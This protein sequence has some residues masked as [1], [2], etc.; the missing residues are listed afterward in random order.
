[1]AVVG[2]G[3]GKLAAAGAVAQ[4]SLN[5][6]QGSDSCSSDQQLQKVLQEVSEGAVAVVSL[7]TGSTPPHPSSNGTVS[8]SSGS[9]ASAGS[10]ALEAL[11][12]SPWCGS[13]DATGYAPQHLV[14]ARSSYDDLI[15]RLPDD[16]LL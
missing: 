9:K 8:S 6:K 3:G 2:G 5:S 13:G 1:M 16:L 14:A 11:Q 10:C 15:S 12:A 4:V 7:V